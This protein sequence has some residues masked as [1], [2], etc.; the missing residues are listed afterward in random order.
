M[1]NEDQG[2]EAPAGRSW[3]RTGLATAAGTGLGGGLVAATPSALG[4]AIGV[5][6]TGPVAGGLFA[7]VTSAGW[8]GTVLYGVQSVCMAG[9]GPA[10]IVVGALA[11][12]V[13]GARKEDLAIQAA[14][15]IIVVAIS[16]G[17]GLAI[18]TVDQQARKGQWLTDYNNLPERL[19]QGLLRKVRNRIAHEANAVPKSTVEEMLAAEAAA[20]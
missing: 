17:T 3:V 19:Q 14:Q 13:I 15:H 20:G 8:G 1:E 10:A 12:A 2:N 4:Y 9:F 11:G 18:L 7:T 5:S 6:A 16:N